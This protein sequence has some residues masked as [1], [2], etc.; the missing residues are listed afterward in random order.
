MFFKINIVDASQ[1]S[2]I[3]C[4]METGNLPSTKSPNPLYNYYITPPIQLIEKPL[5]TIV[6]EADMKT[7]L[8]NDGPVTILMDNQ[9]KE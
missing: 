5:Q 4:E 8:I 1:L 6:F 2:N 9:N 7:A 3:N